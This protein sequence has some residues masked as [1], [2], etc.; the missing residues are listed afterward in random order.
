M[1]KMFQR[2]IARTGATIEAEWNVL[3]GANNEKIVEV[4]D[5]FEPL[6]EMYKDRS[7]SGD[8]S[9]KGSESC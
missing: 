8:S 4:V 5:G 3:T 7:G 9:R 2:G 1:L 6:S